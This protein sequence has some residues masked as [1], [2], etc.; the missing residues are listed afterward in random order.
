MKDLLNSKVPIGTVGITF[1]DSLKMKNDCTRMS[2]YYNCRSC[3]L[4]ISKDFTMVPAFDQISNEWD[5]FP[6]AL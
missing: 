4:S 5:R 2:T 6:A 3:D 1:S